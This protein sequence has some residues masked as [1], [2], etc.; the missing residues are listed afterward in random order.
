MNKKKNLKEM[1]KFNKK[2]KQ[3]LLKL[4]LKI[5]INCKKLKIIRSSNYFTK[6]K[7]EK[8]FLI[9]K[10]KEIQPASNHLYNKHFKNKLRKIC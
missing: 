5:K 6:I 2:N 8:N 7:F 4:G 9:F 1:K 3:K 10:F